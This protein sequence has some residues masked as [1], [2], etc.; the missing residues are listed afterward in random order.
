ML[1]MRR[2]ERLVEAAAVELNAPLLVSFIATLVWH[3]AQL[4]SSGHPQLLLAA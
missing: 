2:R 3:G 1:P 4:P